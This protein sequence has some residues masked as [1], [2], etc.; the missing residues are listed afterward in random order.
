MRTMLNRLVL[1]RVGAASASVGMFSLPIPRQLAGK[2]SIDHPQVDTQPVGWWER[3]E[4]SRREMTFVIGENGMPDQLSFNNRKPRKRKASDKWSYKISTTTERLDFVPHSFPDIPALRGVPAEDCALVEG[5]LELRYGRNKFCLQCGATGPKGG[6]HWW[7]NVQIDPLWSNSVAQAIRVGG[8]VYNADTYLWGDLYLI[9][10]SNGVMQVNAHFVNTKLHIEP[11]D[12]QGLPVIRFSGS[13]FKGIRQKKLLPTTDNRFKFGRSKIN[14]SDSAY[15]CSKKFPGRIKGRGDKVEWW[16]VAQVFNPQLADA[17]PGEWPIG[18]ARTFSFQVSLS[19]ATPEI[20]R[21]RVPSWWYGV[22]GE[23]W[24]WDYLPVTGRN[25]RSSEMF[26]EGLV[27]QQV[28][29]RFDAGVVRS[30][31]P[32]GAGMLGGDGDVGTGLMHHAYH[33]GRDDLYDAALKYCTYWSDLAVDH[34]DFTVHQWV[35]GWGWKT[36][37]YNKFRDVF[38]AYLETGDPY[39][40]DTAEM[41]AEA[42]WMWYRTNWPR[43]SIGRDNFEVGGWALLWRFL[44]TEHAR[45]R[46]EEFVRMNKTLLDTRGVIGGQ[47]GAGP[48]PGY[49]SSLYMTG[50]TMMS[51]MDVA[52]AMIEDPEHD[53]SKEIIPLM[54]ELHHHFMRDDVEMFPSNIGCNRDMW[55]VAVST[56]WGAI[57]GRIY[58]ELARLQGKESRVT[59]SGLIESHRMFP[60]GNDDE[61]GS[62]RPVML[63]SNPIYADALQLG[64]RVKGRGLEICPLGN[65]V[66]LPPQQTVETP[67]GLLTVTTTLHNKRASLH[68]AAEETFPVTIIYKGKKTVID[69]NSSFCRNK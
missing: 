28:K 31:Q 65:L 29:G 33:T 42:Y 53:R 34:S 69:S 64:A 7:Q 35:G 19:K 56:I 3:D 63:A 40:L 54:E 24:P 22:S 47:M 62:V 43:N 1:D 37:A 44:K 55:T 25:S 61:Y 66:D 52:E 67:M 6:P 12:F 36:C 68:L 10:F 58:S 30:S 8:I 17:P 14:L 2:M 50:A 46:C 57:G 60:G 45:L 20:C 32:G 49:F 4:L 38:Y 26:F 59:R 18:F 48:H 41:S 16:P 39:F 11:Y 21:Y 15:L 5:E 23:L 9:L 13:G 51:L 27:R